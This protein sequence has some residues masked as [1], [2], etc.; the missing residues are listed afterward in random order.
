MAEA[1]KKMDYPTMAHLTADVY[2]ED[3]R[4]TTLA[5][6]AMKGEWKTEF[7]ELA[8][9]W[10]AKLAPLKTKL[11]ELSNSLEKLMK[12]NRDVLFDGTDRVDLCYGAL[13]FAVQKR[14]KRARNLLA[15]LERLGAEEAIIIT[16]SVDWDALEKWTDER[17]I[18][19]G[20]ERLQEDKFSWEVFGLPE[21]GKPA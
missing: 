5:L 12:A 21:E 7:D 14:V 1:A 2:L 20:T 17:L 13:L 6:R 15:G 18:E 19:A 8:L 16:K 11:D 10:K 4:A 3:I 9:R